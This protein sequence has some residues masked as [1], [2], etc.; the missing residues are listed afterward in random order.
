MLFGQD[1]DGEVRVRFKNK[2][3]D[4]TESRHSKLACRLAA[5]MHVYYYHP[6]GFSIDDLLHFAILIQSV[7]IAGASK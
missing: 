2:V 1:N 7:F 6:Q 3:D 4:C 5:G